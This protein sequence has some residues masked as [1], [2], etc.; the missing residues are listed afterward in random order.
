MNTTSTKTGYAPT[1]ERRQEQTGSQPFGW[2][3]RMLVGET[4]VKVQASSP[5]LEV[6][7]R[8]E[9][10]N[11]RIAPAPDAGCAVE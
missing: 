9:V 2:I 1:I 8:D 7:G 4:L 3:V 6:A 11:E 5:Q 10:Q